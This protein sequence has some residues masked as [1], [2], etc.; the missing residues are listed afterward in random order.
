M[1]GIKDGLGILMSIIRSYREKN[2][3]GYWKEML[4]GREEQ[5]LC[6]IMVKGGVHF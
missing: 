2:E 6:Y 1:T 5:I 3:L 4:K